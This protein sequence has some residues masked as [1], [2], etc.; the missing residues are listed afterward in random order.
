MEKKLNKTISYLLLLVM[1]ACTSGVKDDVKK[2]S[3]YIKKNVSIMNVSCDS[4]SR[5]LNEKEIV[6]QTNVFNQIGIKDSLRL[7]TATNSKEIII[8]DENK[9]YKI[10]RI[11]ILLKNQK[12]TW[13]VYY[14]DE[15][16]ELLFVEIKSEDPNST[17][18][19]SN[20]PNVTKI[21]CRLVA[22]SNF[23]LNKFKLTEPIKFTPPN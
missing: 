2:Q 4:I 16:K 17:I 11:D 9:K 22:D 1:S 15:L 10:N 3:T 19:L 20:N 6:N 12:T 18:Y 8:Q 14:T 21:L 23:I 5:W 13:V 7:T